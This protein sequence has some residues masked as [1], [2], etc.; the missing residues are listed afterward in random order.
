[1]EIFK[2]NSQRARLAILFSWLAVATTALCLASSIMQL[3]LL[4]SWADGV[5]VDD[6]A[7]AGNDLREGIAALMSSGTTI[8]W[9]VLFLMWFYRARVNLQTRVG[10][11]LACK[12]GLAVGNFFIPIVCLYRPYQTMK[13]LYVDT[14]EL[15][16]KGGLNETTALKTDHV[17]WWW[18][19]WVISAFIANIILRTMFREVETLDDY[20]ALTR[21]EIVS[22]VLDMVSAFLTVIVIRDYSRVEPLLE[23]LP[24]AAESSEIT[25]VAPTE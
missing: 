8:A 12:P 3:N 6:I 22:S 18:A 24:A 1:M 7:A 11:P 2:S 20:I 16:V 10:Y 25:E 5:P 15:F 14:R 4:Q 23:S 19:F 13:E 21:S 17:G 9:M